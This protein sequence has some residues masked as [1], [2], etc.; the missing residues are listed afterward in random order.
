MA[1]RLKKEAEEPMSEEDLIE[2]AK[3][4]LGGIIGGGFD[5]IYLIEQKLVTH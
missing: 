4:S 3:A 2:K 1:E 5:V